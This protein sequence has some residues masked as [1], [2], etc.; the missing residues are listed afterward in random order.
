MQY[1]RIK[2]LTQIYRKD[3]GFNVL[4]HRTVWKV[5]RI[6]RSLVSIVSMHRSKSV[7]HDRKSIDTIHVGGRRRYRIVPQIHLHLQSASIRVY[8]ESR[9]WSL[10]CTIWHVSRSDSHLQ[11][12]RDIPTSCKLLNFNFVPLFAIFHTRN[13]SH[14]KMCIIKNSF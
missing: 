1:K 7:I 8:S 12:S 11:N 9:F 4:M 3:S 10:L 14:C 5:N 13:D 6:G 2:K